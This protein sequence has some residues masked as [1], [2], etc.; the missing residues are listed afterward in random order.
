MTEWNRPVW[1]CL[2]GEQPM[3]NVVPVLAFGAEKVIYLHTS[4]PASRNAARRCA[5]FL[6]GR[7]ISTALVE[8][9]AYDVRAVARR[10]LET[11]LK[12]GL[13]NVLL[14]YTG[15]TKP[16]SLAAYGAMPEYVTRLYYD[17]RKGYM[18]NMEPFAAMPPHAPLGVE[19][20]MRLNSDVQINKF[21]SQPKKALQTVPLLLEALRK[22]HGSIND[23]FA[24]RTQVLA[25][26]RGKKG[27][28]TPEEPVPIPFEKRN[29][30][31]AKSIA[32]AM[33]K[34]GLMLKKRD[35]FFPNNDGLSFL[36]GFW[37]EAVVLEMLRSGLE[38][39]GVDASGGYLHKNVTVSWQGTKTLNELDIVFTHDDRLFLVSCTTASESETEKRR[40]QVEDFA[41]KLGGRFARAMVACTLPR[42]IL[43]KI[44]PRKSDA[45]FMPHYEQLL[46]NPGEVVRRF[47][48]NG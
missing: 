9:D 17:P 45:L 16:M 28:K 29:P 26:L 43:E 31:L 44:A 34:D 11:S 7:G 15:G 18:V 41:G 3:P 35:G 10:V 47:I 6:K 38:N 5:D 19:D 40:T 42:E 21:A 32:E 24:Y 39:C 12:E 36:E 14:N 37:W 30:V 13:E 22:D 4:M 8:V 46:K 48:S 2:A 23:M 20:F 1:I 25:R 33:G 27:W